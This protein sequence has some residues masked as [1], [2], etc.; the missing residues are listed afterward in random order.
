MKIKTLKNKPAFRLMYYWLPVIV[1]GIIIF[2]FS[3]THI[4]VVSEIHWQDF[5]VKKLAHIGEYSIFATLLFRAYKKSGLS[6]LKSFYLALVTCFVY[7]AT[8]EIHQ[9]FTPGREPAVRDIL[10]DTFGAFLALSV[11]RDLLTSFKGKTKELVKFA[12]IEYT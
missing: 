4:R 5:A 3:S 12:E 6:S 1:W 8:D 9:S 2:S 7:G 10:I 11:I